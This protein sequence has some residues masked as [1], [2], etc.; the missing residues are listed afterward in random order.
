[1]TILN[2]FSVDLEDWFQGLTSTNPQID[3][4]PTLE[5]RVVLATQTLLAIL[6]THH[7]QATFFV[8]GYVAD[9]YPKLIEQICA[10]GHELGVHG[11]YHR[12]VHQLTP[13][14]F[15]RELE[16]GIAAVERI[17]GERPIGHRAPYFSI[18]ASTPWAF[19]CMQKLG[20]R[21]DSSVFPTRNLLYG[22]PGAP[23][24]PYQVEGQSLL[25]M[26]V[27]TLRLGN[28]ILPMVGG[29]YT[30]AL[31][32]RFT[33]W[34]IRQLNQQGHPVITY[35]HPWELD[36]GQHYN[37]VTPRERLTHYHGRQALTAKLHKLFTDFRF[38]SLD[39][40]FRNFRPNPN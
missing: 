28:K 5:S 18:N 19:D 3:R 36:T 10:D 22:F 40:L 13:D 23:R 1:M 33:R 2:G 32:Y 30:R 24:F 31:P 17:I 6:R 29:F 39:V 21:Y 27:S 38:T 16:Q 37:Q 25:E 4:W 8:L 34:A 12:F 7:V 15:T 11:Y 35:I 26:P 9:Q 20:L 14:E